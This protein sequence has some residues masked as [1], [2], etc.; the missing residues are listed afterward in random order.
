MPSTP[1]SWSPVSD[2]PPECNMGHPGAPWERYNFHTH[3]TYIMIPAGPEGDQIFHQAPFIQFR[4]YH[5]TASPRSWELTGVVAAY[6]VN[7]CSLPPT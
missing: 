4:M 5:I 3:P 1:P 7:H 6:T 2:D